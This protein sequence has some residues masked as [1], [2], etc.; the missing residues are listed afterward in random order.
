MVILRFV[1]MVLFVFMISLVSAVSSIEI[2]VDDN[3]GI[4]KTLAFNYSILSN[5]NEDID[6]APSIICDNLPS[7]MLES[8][9]VSLTA[10]QKYSSR[11]VYGV[12]P[13]DAVSANCVAHVT[14][15]NPYQYDA[16]E[17]FSLNL[18]NSFDFELKICGDEQC[19]ESKNVFINVF[20]SAR[21]RY[22]SNCAY[23]RN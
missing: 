20:C 10:G 12:I 2:S 23:S 9:S 3:L 13:E 22:F 15:M 18:L 21:I 17:E 6:I 14:I 16:T 4:G 19:A 1:Y 11:Y 8:L 7:A 5:V